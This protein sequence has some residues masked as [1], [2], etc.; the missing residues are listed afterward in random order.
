[1]QVDLLPVA[2]GDIA[3]HASEA[4]HPPDDRLHQGPHKARPVKRLVI[5]ARR[6]GEGAP[7]EYPEDVE[8]RRWP[9]VLPADV[10]AVANGLQAG[11]HIGDA[12]NRDQAVGTCAGHAEEPARPVVLEGPSGDGHAAGGHRRPDRV[13]GKG[14]EQPAIEPESQRS[15]PIND[16]GGV[17]GK[18]G[19][20][21]RWARSWGQ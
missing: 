11:A 1:M 6:Q 18:A 12:V 10:H 19:H 2:S 20:R 5:E 4:G 3:R 15:R 8:V 14:L 7:V 9:R 21:C 13:T 17:R 16:L